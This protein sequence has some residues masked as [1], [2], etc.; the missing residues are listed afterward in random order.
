[1]YSFKCFFITFQSQVPYLCSS[2]ILILSVSVYIISSSLSDS[3]SETPSD[4]FAES[5]SKSLS[6]SLSESLKYGLSQ[7]PY[8]FINCFI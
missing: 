6:E 5:F 2:N 4:S 8:F 1:M 3:F 7:I